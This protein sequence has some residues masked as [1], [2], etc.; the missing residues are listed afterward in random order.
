M[1]LF[2]RYQHLFT[3]NSTFLESCTYHPGLPF[4][5]DVYK[6]WSCCNK[7][8]VDFTEFLNIKGCT[9][10]KHSNEKPPEPEKP[11]KEDV[12]IDEKPKMPAP[13]AKPT[14]KRPP[15]ESELTLVEPNIM[16]SLKKEI[17]ELPKQEPAKTEEKEKSDEILPG[18]ICRNGG[19]SCV[20]EGP[21]TDEK[22]CTYHPGVPIFH[23]GM[24]FW[25]CCQRRTSD[26]TMF[27]NQEGCETGNHKWKGD[28]A[29]KKVVKC[30]FDW[31]QTAANVVVTVYAK[32]YD[33]RVSY[34]KVNPIR[35]NV[36]LVFPQQDNNEFNIDLELRGVIDVAKTKVQMFGTKV[37]ITLVKGEAGT[38]PKLD[39]PRQVE[40]IVETPKTEPEPAKNNIGDSDDSDIDLDDLNPVVGAQL[41]ELAKT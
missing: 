2:L 1:A 3:L 4:F 8:S 6:G 40:K 36:H 13:I 19:C 33:Y 23:E 31:H 16:P 25:S 28:E 11:A 30:R 14:I 41:S 34:V 27:M 35:L 17:D 5:H 9:K 20:Y 12:V 7:K 18:T 15:F 24:K 39:F 26:F 29:D 38:W 10:A 32:M 22:V 37:E 21:A